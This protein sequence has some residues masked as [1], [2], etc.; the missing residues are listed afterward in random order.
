MKT[1]DRHKSL[2]NENEYK[3]WRNKVNKLIKQSK[4]NQYQTFI[5][6]NKNNSGSIYKLFQEVGAGKG[7]RKSSNISSVNQN[8]VN[9]EDP[10]E[11]AYTF[12]SFFAN[13]AAKVKG[14][15][16]HSNHSKLKDFFDSRLPDNIKFNISNIEKDKVLKYLST[17]DSCKA[18]G[19]DNIGPKLLKFAAPYIADDNSWYS[20]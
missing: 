12:N 18:T 5:E 4:K 2:G 7:S 14:P 8:G 20:F 3:S 9:I 19:T 15:V 11:M 13:I 17:M 10:K 6:N 1:R 16:K